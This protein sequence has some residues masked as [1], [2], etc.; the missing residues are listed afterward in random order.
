MKFIIRYLGYDPF[1]R[2]FSQHSCVMAV[3]NTAED[4]DSAVH[5][6]DPC[7]AWITS[8]VG[9]LV[10]RQKNDQIEGSLRGSDE[11]NYPDRGCI[12]SGLFHPRVWWLQQSWQ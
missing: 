7:A 6:Q 3:Y 10:L 9:H 12:I 1:S 2:L 11:V 5:G 8:K 4:F